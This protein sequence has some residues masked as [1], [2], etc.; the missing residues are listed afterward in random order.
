[1]RVVEDGCVLFLEMSLGSRD[2]SLFIGGLPNYELHGHNKKCNTK[3]FSTGLGKCYEKT[4]ADL[5]CLYVSTTQVEKKK[6]LLCIGFNVCSVY[7]MS[8]LSLCNF[9]LLLP[10]SDQYLT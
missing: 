8:D 2:D 1:M 9:C 6:T 10:C 3:E 7:G 5:F 4:V